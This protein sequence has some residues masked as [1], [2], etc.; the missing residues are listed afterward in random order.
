MLRN[1]FVEHRIETICG[2]MEASWADGSL[3]QEKRQ[4]P[5]GLVV[6]TVEYLQRTTHIIILRS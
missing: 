4:T 3:S 2:D 1:E 6:S 5:L